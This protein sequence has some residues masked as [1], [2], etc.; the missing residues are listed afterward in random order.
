MRDQQGD[1]FF[2]IPSKHAFSLVLTFPSF[3]GWG[4]SFS[5]IFIL[6]RGARRSL[7]IHFICKV[8]RTMC[9]VGW[10]HKKIPMIKILHLKVIT[11]K[12]SWHWSLD[13]W[14]WKVGY[15][16]TGNSL[17]DWAHELDDEVHRDVLCKLELLDALLL[18]WS[19]S[20]ES[21][22]HVYMLDRQISLKLKSHNMAFRVLNFNSFPPCSD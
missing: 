4:I 7:C 12:Y 18:A 14:I 1:L 13:S 3:R 6:G 8:K 22:I 5:G 15:E 2:F 11:W 10:S 17:L 16:L 9:I 19:I 20:W 21:C